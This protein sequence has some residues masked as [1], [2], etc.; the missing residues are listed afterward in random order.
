MVQNLIFSGLLSWITVF[1]LMG[2]PMQSFTLE[3]TKQQNFGW[4]LALIGFCFILY[5]LFGCFQQ[6]IQHTILVPLLMATGILCVFYNNAPWIAAGFTIIVVLALYYV[7]EDIFYYIDKFQFRGKGLQFFFLAL[8]IFLF[9]YIGITTSLR[10][11]TF[12]SSDQ[13]LGIFTQMFE[14]M[15]NTGRQLTTVE[16]NMPMS[17]F[18]VHIS[19]V[20]Y[21]LLPVYYVFPHA[22]TLQLS[23]A[24]LT[25]LALWPLYLLCRHY[26]LSTKVTAAIG[27]LYCFYPALSGSCLNDFHENCFLPLF[28]LA[29]IYAIET[30]KN[31]LFFLCMMLTLS[32]KED[33]AVLLMML[34]L[35]L[36]LSKK[37]WKKG[38]IWSGTGLS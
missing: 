18:Q 14:F 5:F 2:G 29:L 25:A 38:G 31:I 7:R 22:L 13:D 4:T 26:H 16:R 9:V 1:L 20:F 23:Q 24:F 6:R 36:I 33:A 3:H 21:L 19:P 27:I 17:H 10:Y 28:L 30:K 12:T 11:L 15:K 8:G 32:V 34:G 35:F 37:D